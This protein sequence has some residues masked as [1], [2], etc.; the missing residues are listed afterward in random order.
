MKT[1]PAKPLFEEWSW[2]NFRNVGLAVGMALK[3][4]IS[5]VKGLKLKD[6]WG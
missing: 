1:S 5:M 4:Y 2:L 6:R 3:Y